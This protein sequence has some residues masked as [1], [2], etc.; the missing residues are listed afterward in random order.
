[1]VE[2]K[3][4]SAEEA[5]KLF[6]A[7]GAENA[8]TQEGSTARGNLAGKQL[9]LRVSDLDTGRVRVNLT[10]PV[11]IAHIIQSLIPPAELKKLE[12]Q[13]FQITAILSAVHDGMTGK[14]FEVEDQE[15]RKHVEMSIE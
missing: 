3:K 1:M 15:H 8:K 11:G 6:D 9:K 13:G 7:L 14:V 12:D 10:I 4:I 2:E 5:A